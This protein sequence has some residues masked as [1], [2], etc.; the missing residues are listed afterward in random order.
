MDLNHVIQHVRDT[1]KHFGRRAAL[2]ELEYRA[3]NRLVPFRILN[4]MT[5]ELADIDPKLF[6]SNGFECHFASDAELEA[7]LADPEITEEMSP[8]FVRV[9]RAH[10]DECF[11]VFDA[12]RLVSFGWYSKR[13]T[14]IEKDLL[15]HFD[16]AWVYMYKG[17]TL[18]G[19]RGKR[20]HGIGMSLAAR[21]YTQ[22]GSRGLISYVESDNYPSL[23][24][25]AKMGYRTFGELFAAR[26]FGRVLTWATPGCKPYGF[27]LEWVP[28]RVHAQ[29]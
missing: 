4:G 20:L 23:H 29:I 2:Y 17:Y 21:A 7:A 26:A 12:K 11:G 5:V 3:V 6:E 1:S 24:S 27:S 13:P 10:G 19:Y 8:E 25:T 28:E 18:R 9:A 14:P 16:P 15:L 22:R